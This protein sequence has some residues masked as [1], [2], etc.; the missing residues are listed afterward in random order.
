VSAGPKNLTA[1][2]TWPWRDSGTYA[3]AAL[4]PIWTVGME[5]PVDKG[6]SKASNGGDEEPVLDLFTFLQA[7]PLAKA[8]AQDGI[9]FEIDRAVEADRDI[10]L[11]DDDEPT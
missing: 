9:D 4:N 11:F 10:G 2:A 6:M 8:I 1:D 3:D 7:S 5:V